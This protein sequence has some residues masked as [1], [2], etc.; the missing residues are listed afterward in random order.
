MY[1]VSITY[2]N[3]SQM[4]R[5]TVTTKIWP[6]ESHAL[7]FSSLGQ[8]RESYGALLVPIILSKLPGDVKRNM[9]RQHGNDDWTIDE[10]QGALLTEIRILEMSS[11]HLFKNQH[12]PITASFHASSVRKPSRTVLLVTPK[13]R[14]NIHVCIA[15]D[16][17]LLVH[18]KL[19]RTTRD[20]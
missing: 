12:E 16:L 10:L 5:Y 3:L 7:S 4:N 13:L 2:Y 8:P 1:V 17:M 19:L 6:V 15:R 9:A 14:R 18:V 20:A 11:H